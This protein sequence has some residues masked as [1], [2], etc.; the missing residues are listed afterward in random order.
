MHQEEVKSKHKGLARAL[1]IGDRVAELCNETDT[2]DPAELIDAEI[3]E[4]E[5]GGG[6]TVA[7]TVVAEAEADPNAQMVEFAHEIAEAASEPLSQQATE[8]PAEAVQSTEQPPFDTA[9]TAENSVPKPKQIK[10]AKAQL[11]GLGATQLNKL[12]HD[13]NVIVEGWPGL[14]V[15]EKRE[16]LVPFLHPDYADAVGGPVELAGADKPVKPLSKKAQ[17]LSNMDPLMKLA[18]EIENMDEQKVL[19]SV[20]AWRERESVNFFEIGGYLA[21]MQVNGWFGEHKDLAAFV[22][23]ELGFSYRTARYLIQC[24]EGIC[25]AELTFNQVSKMGWTKLKEL[26]VAGGVL[27]KDNIDEWVQKALTHNVA[28]FTDLVKQA[29]GI[30]PSGGVVLDG[31]KPVK[32]MAFKLFDDQ[33][34]TVKKALAKAKQEGGTENDNVALE[35]IALEYLNGGGSSTAELADLTAQFQTE[36]AVKAFLTKVGWQRSLELVAEVFPA[37]VMSVNPDSMQAQG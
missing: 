4:M 15:A 33:T 7:A 28:E 19:I 27:T 30:E 26:F 24:Y 32:S 13:H 31:D 34:D 11:Q 1:E 8:A 25:E 10:L 16:A 3:A 23:A 22:V 37:L 18:H 21:A 36:E 17:A 2:A 12:A 35:Y 29:K 14:K 6:I 20:R 9:E 5:A